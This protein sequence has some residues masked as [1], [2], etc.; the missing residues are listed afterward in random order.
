MMQSVTIQTVDNDGNIIGEET[1]S[2]VRITDTS[3]IQ[4][5][6][7]LMQ[8]GLTFEEAAARVEIA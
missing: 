2:V 1:S 3:Q 5:M 6:L 7:N 4:E 8:A